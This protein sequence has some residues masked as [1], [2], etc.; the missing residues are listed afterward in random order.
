[1]KGRLR[2]GGFTARFF[3]PWALILGFGLLM[4]YSVTSPPGDFGLDDDGS[5]YTISR[6]FFQRQLMWVLIGLAAVFVGAVIP[7]WI[8]KDYFAWFL[9]GAGLLLLVAL[10]VLPPMRGDT[11]RWLVLGPMGVQPSELFKVVL[12]IMLASVLAARRGDPNGMR[13][14]L[15]TGLIVLPPTLLVL[16]QPDLGTAITLLWLIFPMMIWRG[17]SLRRLLIMTAPVISGFI[18]LYGTITSGG[19]APGPGHILWAVFMI[20]LFFVSLL[21]PTMS[22]LERVGF[23]LASVGVGLAVPRIW[24][25]ML[26]YQQ[27]RILVFFDPGLDPLGAGYQIFQ[28]KVAIGSGGIFGRGFLEGTQK[29]LAFLPARHTDFIFSVVGEEF[30]FIGAMAVLGLYTW[31]IIEGFKLAGKARHPFG[32]LL[33]VGISSLL[34]F[35]VFVN[36]G[37]TIGLMPVTGLPLPGMSFGGSVLVATSFLIGLQMNISRNWGRY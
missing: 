10:L 22:V 16:R 32:Q 14:V 36:V 13:Q 19:E 37:M 15:V 23:Y 29:G 28:S 5:A 26:P 21:Y 11:H 31:L 33:S 9:Y 8:Y 35:H 4:L 7:F 25:G 20:A 34:L 30:G 12:I 6:V 1:M 27:K 17:L 2:H 3:L 18:V 24:S